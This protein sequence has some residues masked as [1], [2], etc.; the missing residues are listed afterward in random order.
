MDEENEN[1]L[2]LAEY[3]KL[4]D[5]IEDFDK[6]A[7]TIKAW[8]VTLSAAGIVTSYTQGSAA[9]L[10]V[11]TVSAFFFWLVEGTWKVNQQC[12]YGRVWRIERS[13]RDHEPIVPLQIATRWS[14]EYQEKKSMLY[15]WRVLWWPHVA[16]PHVM[17]VL[18]G[19]GLLL[20]FQPTP[21]AAN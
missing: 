4:Q 7:L 12:F 2:L 20:G 13:F 17:L 21:S 6:R 3:L 15:L 19:A 8:S 18:L 9:I 1:E 5:I 16:L 11:A 14:S 10:A